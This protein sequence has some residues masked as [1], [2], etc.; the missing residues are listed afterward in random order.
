MFF[1]P[2]TKPKVSS[3]VSLSSWEVLLWNYVRNSAEV[4]DGFIF[5]L[6]GLQKHMA[7]LVVLKQRQIGIPPL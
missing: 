3:Y 2:G 7:I 5:V 4:D 1:V 6:I